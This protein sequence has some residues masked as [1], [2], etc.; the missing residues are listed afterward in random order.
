MVENKFPALPHPYFV[1]KME[2]LPHVQS[3]ARH[4]GRYER[5]IK[6][7]DTGKSE[8][9]T[10]REENSWEAGRAIQEGEVNASK[11][12]REATRFGITKG[13]INQA[14]YATRVPRAQARFCSLPH[15]CV[16]EAPKCSGLLFST[17]KIRTQILSPPRWVIE[18]S[19]LAYSMWAVAS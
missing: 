16:A 8:K 14:A 15:S 12:R 11:G 17:C 5:N 9:S 6:Q 18:I 19:E 3:W 4:Y 13:R 2:C 7:L 10:C 1:N